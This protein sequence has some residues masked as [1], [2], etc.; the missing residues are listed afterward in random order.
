MRERAAGRRARRHPS[1]S[2]GHGATARLPVKQQPRMRF[3][4]HLSVMRCPGGMNE[5]GRTSG[6]F[7]LAVAAVIVGVGGY[8]A[9]TFLRPDPYALSERVVREARR[10]LAYEVREFQRGLDD[11][12]RNAKKA[13]KDPEAAVD[14]EVE[15]ADKAIDDVVSAAR[16]QLADL[17]VELRT[18]RNRMDRIQ[19]RAQEARDIIAEH[20][21]EAKEKA[22]GD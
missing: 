19:T 10:G 11:V 4:F 2:A 1:T 17:D 6:S 13:G 3:D 16:D 5:R 20:A 14:S 21:E 9:W 18:Q 7:L 15:K 22:T 12:V 8:A